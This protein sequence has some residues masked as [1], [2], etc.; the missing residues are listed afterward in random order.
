MICTEADRYAI[1]SLLCRTDSAG[2]GGII[3]TG[4]IACA[5]T[6]PPYYLAKVPGEGTAGFRRG[7]RGSEK[8]GL[9]GHGSDEWS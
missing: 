4:E 7:Q 2:G 8:R 3:T 6:I 5:E 1:R 9:D